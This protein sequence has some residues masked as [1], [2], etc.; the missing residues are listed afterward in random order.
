MK[1]LQL[2]LINLML[3]VMFAFPAY[4]QSTW[5]PSSSA[6]LVKNTVLSMDAFSS[7]G[8]GTPV[9][10]G[11]AQDI[12]ATVSCSTPGC[13]KTLAFQCSW[14]VSPLLSQSD[15]LTSAGD[16]TKPW[17]YVS[18][19]DMQDPNTL[20]TSFQGS[21]YNWTANITKTFLLNV[22]GCTQVTPRIPS[23]AAAGNVSVAI[24]YYSG[25]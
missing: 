3:L 19:Y 11:G 14:R 22:D 24:T 1:K 20:I 23:S 13:D 16:V 7:V 2:L 5:V 15:F 25:N 17:S 8:V 10:V 9:D 12:Y 4:S 21:F 18:F 6:G